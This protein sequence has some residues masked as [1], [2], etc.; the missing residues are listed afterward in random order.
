MVSFRMMSGMWL[1]LMCVVLMNFYQS[2][3]TSTFA[4][5]KMHP[6]IETMEQLMQ[7]KDV[8]V[9]TFENTYPESCFK[10]KYN[11]LYASI[12]QRMAGNLEPNLNDFR[13][14]PPWMDEVEDGKVV[15][16][17]ENM[18]MRA[19]I[20]ERFRQTG[21]CNIR[22]TPISFCSAYIAIAFNKQFSKVVKEQFEQN[23][24]KFVEAG[25]LH[26]SFIASTLYYDICTQA[27]NPATKALSLKDLF[28]AFCLLA[29]GM[30]ISLLAFTIEKVYYRTRMI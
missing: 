1:I 8:R 13:K 29:F 25:L 4:N 12:W 7:N 11:V 28:G 19:L 30:I 16:F 20:G 23:L 9:E 17:S 18:F 27:K 22:A 15:F 10:N 3:I 6:K 2:T 26:R 5:E 14:I 21:K 24:L